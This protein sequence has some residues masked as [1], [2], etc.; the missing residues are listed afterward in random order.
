MG[1]PGI[2]PPE[3]IGNIGTITQDLMADEEILG[4][5]LL[6]PSSE[7]NLRLD[8]PASVRYLPVP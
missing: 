8:V 4:D 2:D 3:G 7:L 1:D 6:D 5:I